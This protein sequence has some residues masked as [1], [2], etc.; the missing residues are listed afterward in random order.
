MEWLQAANV[1]VTIKTDRLMIPQGDLQDLHIGVK[2]WDGALD[3]VPISFRESE[4]SVSGTVQLGPSNGGYALAVSLKAENAH[5]GLLASEEQDRTTLPP[6]GGQLELR[7]TGKSLHELMA[8]S[9]GKVSLTQGKG[10]IKDLITSQLFGDLILEIIRTLN[11]LQTAEEYTTLQCGIYAVY[12]QDGVATIEHLAIQTGRMAFVAKG[13]VNFEDEKLNLTM[14]AT[15]REG[16]GI[17]IG[18][19]ANSFLK[20]GGTLRS[21]KLKIDPTA[22]IT[23]TGAAV[24]TGGLSIV[25]KSLWDRAKAQSDICKDRKRQR[26]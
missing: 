20:L 4:G 26:S 11:P 13:N 14:S 8:S 5:L 22:S 24:A 3:I 21:P 23:T 7:G 9:N 12:I 16:L 10:R 15:P 1:N 18:G 2:L 19:V 25:A 6:L 17:S